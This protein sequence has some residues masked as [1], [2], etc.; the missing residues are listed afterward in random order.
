MTTV[1]KYLWTAIERTY[2]SFVFDTTRFQ[3][4]VRALLKTEG[5]IM[6]SV[7]HTGYRLHNRGIVV[8]F[9]VGINTLTAPVKVSRLAL[10]HN[11]PPIQRAPCR[12]ADHPH[13]PSAKL[14]N[15]WSYASP[16]H[17]LSWLAQGQLHVCNVTTLIVSRTAT[18]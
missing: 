2:L 7:S 15:E 17:T 3:V 6:Y 13:T 5:G 16:P 9:P 10:G 1:H 11:Q 14:K 4:S 12:E 18:S 8:R